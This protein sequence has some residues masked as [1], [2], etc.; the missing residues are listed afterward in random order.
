MWEARWDRG[1]GQGHSPGFTAEKLTRQHI[2]GRSQANAAEQ[3]IDF[4]GSTAFAHTVQGRG[5]T[6]VFGNGQIGEQIPLLEDKA[7]LSALKKAMYTK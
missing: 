6:D 4:L 1:P 2:G 3:C 7:Q 5:K